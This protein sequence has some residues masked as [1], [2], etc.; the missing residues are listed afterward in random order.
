[1]DDRFDQ[2]LWVTLL[3][4]L[5]YI[6]AGNGESYTCARLCEINTISK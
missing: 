3:D 6:G 2:S 5:D 1:M 4:C